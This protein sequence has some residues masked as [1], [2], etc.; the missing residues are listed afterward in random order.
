MIK[1]AEDKKMKVCDDNHNEA[2]LV[3]NQNESIIEIVKEY[4][5]MLTDAE[6]QEFYD[7]KVD[8]FYEFINHEED[9]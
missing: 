6:V 4:M 2:F 8:Y 9:L 3:E 7:F 5:M 1:E